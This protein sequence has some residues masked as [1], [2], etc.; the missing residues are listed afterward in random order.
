[1]LDPFELLNGLTEVQ[2]GSWPSP[3]NGL[4]IG[5]RNLELTDRDKQA[6]PRPAGRSASGSD[7]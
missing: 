4:A 1:M 7:G 6:R 3:F 2:L 5:R